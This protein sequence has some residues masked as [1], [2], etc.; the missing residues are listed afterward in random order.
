M[1]TGITYLRWNDLLAAHF[2]SPEMAGRAVYLY[3]NEELLVELGRPWGVG[4]PEFLSAVKEGPP[5]ATREGICQK[6][7]QGFEGWRTRALPYPSYI[8]YLGL[9][10]MAAGTE[11]NFATH[12][13][14][15]RLR[16]ILGYPDGGMPPSFEKML[17]LWADLEQWSTGEKCGELGIFSIRFFYGGWIHVGLPVAQSILTETERK[18]LPLIFSHAA[19][20]PTSPPPSLELARALREHGVGCLRQR[21]LKLLTT[22][23]D[24]DLY[25]V[26]LDAVAEELAEWD[27]QI[28]EDVQTTTS[29]GIRS[30]AS[31]R[32]CLSMDSTARRVYASLRCKLNREFPEG[33]LVLLTSGFSSKLSCEEILHGWSSPLYETATGKPVDAAQFD[34]ANGLMLKDDRLSWQFRLQGRGVHIFVTGVGEG[35]PGLVETNALPRASPFYL[36][37]KNDCWSRLETWA[38][39]ECLDFIDHHIVEGLPHAWRLASIRE[40]TGDSKIRDLFPFLSFPKGTRLRFVGGIRSTLGNHYFSFTP[41]ELYLENAEGNEQVLCCGKVLHSTAGKHYYGLPNKLQMETRI[42]IEVKRGDTVIKRISLYLTG[43]YSWRGVEPVQEFDR[44]GLSLNNSS[45][46]RVRVAGA[47]VTGELPDVS[48]FK[49]PVFLATVLESALRGRIFF[50]GRKP[51]EIVSWPVEPIPSSWEPMW[52]IPLRR[53]GYAVYCGGNPSDCGPVPEPV[54]NKQRVEQWKDILWYRRKLIDPPA[55]RALLK[56]WKQY[57]ELASNV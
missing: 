13:Y 32:L 30:H 6:A 34:W 37:Y 42:P 36:A 23:E 51:G 35:L 9:F 46:Q 43:E 8:A 40:A 29:G 16:R 56:L 55:H 52:A 28:S 38:Q 20:D 48:G 19:V 45:S 4:V 5:W 33:H 49:R 54:S 41:P 10:V 18:S 14:Y 24:E 3:V 7:Y 26:L 12:A 11:G 50:V 21:T 2:F 1:A 27:G 17:D 44:W 53:L 39:E 25:R 22:H 31:L 47:M 15:P 57:Q